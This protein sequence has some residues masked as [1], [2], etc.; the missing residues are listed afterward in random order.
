MTDEDVVAISNWARLGG[1]HEMNSDAWRVV[2]RAACELATGLDDMRRHHLFNALTDPRPE[3]YSGLPGEVP[4]RFVDAVTSA[5]A[6]LQQETE[7]VLESFWRWN[8]SLAEAELESERQ[9]AKED[10]GE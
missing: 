2:A 9:R 1:V 3:A 7:P 5:Q 6:L 10:R 8:L 4:D